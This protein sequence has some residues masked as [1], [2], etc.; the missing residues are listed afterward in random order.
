MRLHVGLP[1]LFWAEAVNIAAHLINRGPS[2]P[3]N[4]KLSD[5]VWSGRKVNLSYLKVFDC[6]S[7]MH[8]DFIA[9]TKL[10]TKSKK[11]FVVGYGDSEL[12]Y[13]F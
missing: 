6:V 13:R 4:F 3:L 12:G 9:R 11:C 2:T 8:I 5:E 10:D 7:Y 1:K